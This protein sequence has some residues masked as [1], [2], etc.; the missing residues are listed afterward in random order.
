MRK[1]RSEASLVSSGRASTRVP[2]SLSR[3]GAMAQTFVLSERGEV[4]SRTF[5]VGV[6]P[7]CTCGQLLGRRDVGDILTSSAG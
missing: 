7:G 4:R 2:P 6:N 5:N 1:R 3:E